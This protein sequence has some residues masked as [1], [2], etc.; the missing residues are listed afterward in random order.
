MAFPTETIKRYIAARYPILYL[1][2]WEEDRVERMLSLLGARLFTTPI[3]FYTWS[4][5]NGLRSNG[6][7]VEN[8]NDLIQALDRITREEET[9]FYLFKDLHFFLNDPRLIRKLREVYRAL[10][11]SY[12]T[13]FILSPSLILPYELEKEVTVIDIGLPDVDE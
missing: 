13:L 5:I 11:T 6:I 1:V 3:K 4:C 9:G 12:K 7:E 8:T 2:S 10:R